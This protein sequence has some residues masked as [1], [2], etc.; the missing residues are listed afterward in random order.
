MYIRHKLQKG[1]ISRE[2]PPKEEEMGA[3]ANF[4]QKLE[5]HEELEVSMI[6]STKIHRVLKMIAKLNSIPKDEEY[7][8]RRRSIDLLAK[9]KNLLDSDLPA[10]EKEKE[11]DSEPTTNGVHKETEEASEAAEKIEKAADKESEEDKTA[12]EAADKGN[13]EAPSESKDEEMPDVEAEE[14]KQDEDLAKEAPKEGE[15]ENSAEKAD[16]KTEEKAAEK[17]A[18]ETA[19]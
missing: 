2:Y 8:F 19:A 11:K 6:R 3:M 9:W 18:E 15:T 12:E 17:P 5:G 7:H 16:E 1:F 13:K 4:F 10:D 14:K